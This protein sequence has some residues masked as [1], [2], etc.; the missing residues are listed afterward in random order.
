MFRLAGTLT[1]SHLMS[2]WVEVQKAMAKD[3]AQTQFQVDAEAKKKALNKV[4]KLAEREGRGQRAGVITIGSLTASG[5]H[6]QGLHRQN[7]DPG[8]QETQPTLTS[9]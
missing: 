8:P 3:L 7:T 4:S 5:L 9:V 2:G 6:R 1:A